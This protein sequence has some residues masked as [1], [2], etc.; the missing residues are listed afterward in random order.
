[1]TLTP[2]RT[3]TPI[4]PN[5]GL[6]VAY[7][8]RLEAL[9]DQMVAAVNRAILAA[10][11]ENPPLASDASPAAIMQA[12]FRRISKRWLKRFDK[13]APQI[14]RYFATTAQERSDSAFK[15]AL[16]DAG[17]TV[18]FRLSRPVNDILQ[19]VVAENVSLIRSIASQYLTQV[20][21]DV[22]R[23]V[24][25]GRDLATLSDALQ[26]R[27]GVTRRRAV[28]IARDQN[29]KATAMIT[30]ARQ[31]ELGITRAKWLHSAGGN[32]PRPE[33]VAFSG[34]TYDIE[35][36]H[37]FDNGEGVV[38]P[39]TAINCRCVSVPVVPGFDDE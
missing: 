5:A 23:S 19:A 31:R 8:K 2:M 28:T 17:F 35:K 12:A 21:G 34:K 6:T 1:M 30:R 37:D 9:V 3:L 32:H 25:A 38:W 26:K 16:R 14:A 10:Y 29:N 33:H 24:A 36:G 27:A 18:R 4:R 22:M 39:G 15:A 7:Q 20:E 11:R 13:L